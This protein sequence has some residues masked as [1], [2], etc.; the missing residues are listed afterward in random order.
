MTLFG[1][2]GSHH[3]F[4]QKMPSRPLILS[5]DD[6]ARADFLIWRACLS[7]TPDRT[8]D[9]MR[10]AAMAH[11]VPFCAY[12]FPYPR[13]VSPA[14][15]QARRL[16]ECIGDTRIPVMMDW[17]HDGGVFARLD[18]LVAVV[19]EVRALGYR[20]TLTY[21]GRWFWSGYVGSPTMSGHGFDLVNS[22]YPDGYKLDDHRAI[23]NRA[24]GDQGRGWRGY[25]GLTPVLWQFTSSGRWGNRYSGVANHMDW[26]AYKGDAGGLHRWFYDPQY[27]DPPKP[28]PPPHTGS[29]PPVFDDEEDDMAR[30]DLLVRDTGG[31]AYVT[32][33]VSYANRVRENPEDDQS[34]AALLRDKWRCAARPDGSP[35][36]LND[37]ETALI[38]RIARG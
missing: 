35:W 34:E 1:P 25:G 7:R 4:D 20:V 33:M 31:Q 18:D 6:W 37:V 24:G 2:D 22:D 10:D 30:V 19:N 23:Y 14:V 9:P 27:D 12:H 36:P 17:E 13:D 11:R 15:E 26:N 3:Q 5:D 21:T 32:D 28:P 16:H 8:F 29:N 38:Q